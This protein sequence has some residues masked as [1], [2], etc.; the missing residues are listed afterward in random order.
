MECITTHHRCI[1]DRR[2][3]VTGKEEDCIGTVDEVGK[4]V[5]TRCVM[6]FMMY[7][8][9]GGGRKRDLAWC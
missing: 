3:G 2:D 7:R 5:P 9:R 8:Q 4:V 1:Q 6:E